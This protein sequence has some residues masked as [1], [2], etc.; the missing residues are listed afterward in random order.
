M[1]VAGTRAPQRRRF[2]VMIAAG[3]ALFFF[4]EQTPSR[5]APDLGPAT[6]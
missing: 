2:L 1:A 6:C 5:T 4:G 3:M